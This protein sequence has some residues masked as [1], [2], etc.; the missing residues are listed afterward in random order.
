M[1]PSLT[2]LAPADLARFVAERRV[3]RSTT[4]GRKP[5]RCTIKALASAWHIP[6]TILAD[7]LQKLLASSTPAE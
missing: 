2:T 7:E 4:P 3:L 5:V 6:E 1:T